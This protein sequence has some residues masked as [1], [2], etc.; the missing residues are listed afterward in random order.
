[1]LRFPPGLA[2]GTGDHQTTSSC[3]EL[4]I[5][6]GADL[7]PGWSLL[8]L[9]TGTGILAIAA[10]RLGAGR[11]LA[12]DFDPK[13]IEVAR[14]SLA[15]HQIAESRVELREA[16]VL[17]WEPGEQFGVVTA[18]LFGA[19]LIQAMPMIRA[20]LEPGGQAIFSGILREQTAARAVSA[21]SANLAVERSLERGKW[22]TLAASVV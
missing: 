13:A 5:R 1:M 15:R 17:A 9:G 19:V 18:N 10:A 22:V 7:D 11:I 14:S 12:V 16:D 21:T 6:A 2:F 8:D 3:L 20:A 4:L